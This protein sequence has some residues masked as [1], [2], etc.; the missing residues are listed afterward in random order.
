MFLFLIDHMDQQDK[1][2]ILEEYLKARKWQ[3][4]WEKKVTKQNLKIIDIDVK[5]IF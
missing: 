5:I 4:E 3:E 2:K 1:T